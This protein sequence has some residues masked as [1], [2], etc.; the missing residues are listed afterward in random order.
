MANVYVSAGCNGAGMTTAIY[1]VLTG[2]LNGKKFVNVDETA[3]D[4][5]SFQC[6]KVAIPF[7]RLLLSQH[8]YQH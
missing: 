8:Q 7:N 2:R 6:C 1:S 4:L 3:K 5:S